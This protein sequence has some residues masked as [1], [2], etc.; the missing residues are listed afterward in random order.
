MV[1]VLE[2]NDHQ[3]DMIEVTSSN[4]LAIG[5]FPDDE[6]LYVEFKGGSIY[7]YTQVKPGRHSDFMAADSK[8]AW[9]DANIRK[10]GYQYKKIR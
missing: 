2:Y 4:I 10:A 7:E 9:H 3:V 5:Y 1:W 6:K 8:G